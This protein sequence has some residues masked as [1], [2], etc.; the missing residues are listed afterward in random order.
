[1][2][3]L[4]IRL[5]YLKAAFHG[6]PGARDHLGWLEAHL[7]QASPSVAEESEGGDKP[8]ILPPNTEP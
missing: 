8:P 1:M 4:R 5:E 2:Q 3:R 7:A 6:V